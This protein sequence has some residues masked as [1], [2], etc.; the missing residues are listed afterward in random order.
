MNQKPKENK[1]KMA[2]KNISKKIKIKN[3]KGKDQMSINDF[4]KQLKDFKEEFIFL[5]KK[6]NADINIEKI[7][8]I[9]K[10]IVNKI[11]G[12][13]N[14]DKEI[15]EIEDEDEDENKNKNKKMKIVKKKMM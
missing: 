1:E 13:T 14:E 2:E 11:N 15:N 4:T 8:A 5:N 10:N 3:L 6:R 9:Q 12:A 7:M